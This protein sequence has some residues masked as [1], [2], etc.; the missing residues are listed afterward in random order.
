MIISWLT[1]L[2]IG[3]PL[4]ILLT[5]AVTVKGWKDSYDKTVIQERLILEQQEKLKKQE[6]QARI[7]KDTILALTELGNQQ[8]IQYEELQKR[9][10]EIDDAPDS[11]DGPIAPVLRRTL[12]SL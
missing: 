5:F 4:A 7:D 2:R 1:L 12:D 11:D 10:K 3:I 8:K 9:L 6:A